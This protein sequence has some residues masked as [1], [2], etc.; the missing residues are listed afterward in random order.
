M[1]QL[2]TEH[3]VAVCQYLIGEAETAAADNRAFASRYHG[4]ERKTVLLAAEQ[5]DG[6]AGWIREAQ[7]Q[8][9]AQLERP[10]TA[11]SAA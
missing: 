8:M 2:T 5:W 4:S 11:S 10:M 9:T 3:V 6:R 7:S 1:T